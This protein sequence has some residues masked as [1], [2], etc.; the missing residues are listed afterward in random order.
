MFLPAAPPPTSLPGPPPPAPEPSLQ[1]QL[2]AINSLISSSR[3]STLLSLSSLGISS[4]AS[5]PL[6]SPSHSI[7]HEYYLGVAQYQ[8]GLAADSVPNL[9]AASL[10]SPDSAEIHDALGQAL[11]STWDCDGAAE[12]YRTALSLLPPGDPRELYFRA[13]ILKVSSWV[14]SYEGN[15]R[16]TA[17]LL[18]DLGSSPPP[19]VP[20][21]ST[22][23]FPDNVLNRLP[24]STLLSLSHK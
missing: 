24:P 19:A 5:L 22:S 10:L 17:Q 14:S 20:G 4:R 9:R 2:A 3:W 11:M 1:D 16:D 12:S 6:A 18:R 21:L 8:L 13:R 15:S 23:D 7:N